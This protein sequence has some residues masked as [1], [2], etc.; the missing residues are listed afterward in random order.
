MSAR[1]LA[2]PVVAAAAALAVPTPAGAAAP[3]AAAALAPAGSTVL[4]VTC[5]SPASILHTEP[6]TRR[7][8]AL[9]VKL[10]DGRRCTS[11]ID[12]VGGTQAFVRLTPVCTPNAAKAATKKPKR[13][14]RR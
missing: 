1:R 10:L 11:L 14:R 7:L 6:G 3:D 12:V 2:V 9:Q 5:G 8:C 13:A 4:F